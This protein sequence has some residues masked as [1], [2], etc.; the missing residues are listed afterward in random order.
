[1]TAPTLHS[2]LQSDDTVNVQRHLLTRP[3]LWILRALANDMR[4]EPA[5]AWNEDLVWVRHSNWV[6]TRTIL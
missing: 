4:P 1:M 2:Y 3:M 5:T 6:F